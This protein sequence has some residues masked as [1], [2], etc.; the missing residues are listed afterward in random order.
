MDGI[1]RVFSGGHIERS[2]LPP[3]R[4]AYVRADLTVGFSIEPPPADQTVRRTTLTGPAMKDRFHLISSDSWR[5]GRS[6]RTVFAAFPP[7]LLIRKRFLMSYYPIIHLPPSR[8]IELARFRL[9]Y[10]TRDSPV[11][12]FP[13]VSVYKR[14]TTFAAQL[15]P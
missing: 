11:N 12:Q 2:A 14:L 10:K 6:R 13:G 8:S 3:D 5:S 9:D 15:D 1:D 4:V 7:M